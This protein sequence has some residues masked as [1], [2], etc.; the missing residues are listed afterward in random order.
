LWVGCVIVKTGSTSNTIKTDISTS[1]G[2]TKSMIHAPIQVVRGEYEEFVW[3]AMVLSQP[4][5]SRTCFL[6]DG[7]YR[8]SHPILNPENPSHETWNRVTSTPV[9]SE[10]FETHP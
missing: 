4:A 8:R 7:R 1:T 6:E 9:A 10:A 2:T 3:W 5:V